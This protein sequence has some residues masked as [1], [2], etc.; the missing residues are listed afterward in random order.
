MIDACRRQN[1][2][3]IGLM[4]LLFRQLQ[5]KSGAN[6]KTVSRMNKQD[7]QFC[8]SSVSSASACFIS[9]LSEY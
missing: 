2:R 4:K 1:E 7:A 9:S 5:V 6:Q 3:L 8:S